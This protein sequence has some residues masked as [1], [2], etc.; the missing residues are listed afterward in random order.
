MKKNSS[1]ENSNVFSNNKFLGAKLWGLGVKHGV[2]TL[3]NMF[4]ICK[5][6]S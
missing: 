2:V 4:H 5:F 1:I 3:P 6:F